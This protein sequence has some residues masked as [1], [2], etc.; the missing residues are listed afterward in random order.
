MCQVEVQKRATDLN[1]TVAGRRRRGDL[2]S[3][4]EG[5]GLGLNKKGSAG[6]GCS[7]REAFGNASRRA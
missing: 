7:G 4:A 1:A 5:V 2:L 3:F 6:P